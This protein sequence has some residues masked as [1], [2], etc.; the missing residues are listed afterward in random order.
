MREMVVMVVRNDDRID[1]RDILNLTRHVCISLGTHEAERRASLREDGI[2]EDSQTAREFDIEASMSEP[3]RSQSLGLSRWQ[4]LRFVH[5]H[6]RRCGIWISSLS[7]DLSEEDVLHE[8]PWLDI[9]VGFPRIDE[10]LRL[11]IVVFLRGGVF[12]LR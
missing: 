3:C 1:V 12:R 7:R 6:S 2:E 11:G 8:L 9:A 10:T 5:W 4:K